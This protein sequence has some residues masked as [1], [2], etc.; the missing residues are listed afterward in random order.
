MK[1]TLPFTQDQANAILIQFPYD[2]MISRIKHLR[3]DSSLGLAEAKTFT[4]NFRD[5]IAAGKIKMAVRIEGSD[6]GRLDPNRVASLRPFHV[7]T[8]FLQNHSRDEVREAVALLG[9]SLSK[10]KIPG[11]APGEKVKATHA[12]VLL[13]ELVEYLTG[14][15]LTV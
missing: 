5:L 6:P 10:V 4:E 8:T 15:A 13:G 14:T 2:G 9:E 3:E 12:T 11:K 1:M 7:S